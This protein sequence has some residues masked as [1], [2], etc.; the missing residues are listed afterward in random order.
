MLPSSVGS[1]DRPWLSPRAAWLPLALMRKLESQELS[2]LIY[3]HDIYMY[4]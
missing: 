1:D 3:V 4:L 2:L